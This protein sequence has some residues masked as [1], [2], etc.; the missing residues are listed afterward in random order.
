MSDQSNTNESSTHVPEAAIIEEPRLQ[1]L[2]IK[3]SPW[4]LGSGNG[5]A[6]IC[7]DRQLMGR[8]GRR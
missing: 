5:R 2:L 6:G 8:H 1:D 3:H 7:A 4:L